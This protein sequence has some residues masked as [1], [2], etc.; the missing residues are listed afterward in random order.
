MIIATVSMKT[1]A[2]VG[3]TSGKIS[4]SSIVLA[5]I[6]GQERP[7]NDI[8]VK[9]MNRTIALIRSASEFLQGSILH[10][11]QMKRFSLRHK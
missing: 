1:I 8:V 9:S 5:E 2:I 6:S 7:E 10:R 11:E 4:E 3:P